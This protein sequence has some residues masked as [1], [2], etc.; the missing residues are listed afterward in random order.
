MTI[1]SDFFKIIKEGCPDAFS[2]NL[3]FKPDIVFIDGQVKLM[4]ATEIN[5]WNLFFA[6][7][8][9]KTIEK[10][11]ALGANTVVLAFD[12]Y[13]HVPS[14]KNM[15]QVKRTK[16]K[17]VLDFANNSKLPVNMPE[18]WAGAMANRTFKVKVINKVLEA[19][20]EW[21]QTKLK[22]DV[23]YRERK[24]VLDYAGVPQLIQ[25]PTDTVYPIQHFINEYDWMPKKNTVGR[26]E[27]D[28]KA[29]VWMHVCKFLCVVSTDGDYLPLALLQTREHSALGTDLQ[30]NHMH[31]NTNNKRVVLYRMTT[32]LPLATPV[33][34]KQLDVEGRSAKTT[35]KTSYKYEFVDIATIDS[36]VQT[37][38]PS[39]A[40]D[41]VRQFC[42]MIAL[43][44]C[45]FVR[46][47]P[48]L[49][50]RTLWKLR[51]MLLH[52]DLREV[53]Q[54]MSALSIAYS[55]LYIM[56]NK[57]PPGIINSVEWFK[58][59]S[60]EQMFAMFDQVSAKIQRTSSISPRIKQQLWQAD[61][62]MAHARNTVWTMH[63]W[64][65]CD[66]CPDPHAT[67]VGDFGYVR[68]SKGR[69]HFACEK[70][71]DP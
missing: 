17:V 43:C 60:E 67:E 50:P 63:Y 57:M 42:A 2:E 32:Q 18:D 7:Q 64:T 69:T 9:Y 58:N 34:R 54:I 11:F 21:F 44:G 36:W 26:G 29:F 27:C 25:L 16:Q 20:S 30:A 47:L 38:F 15:T 39:K 35:T 33:K 68:D 59:A 14:S 52:I 56:K 13:T 40:T 10:C 41:P 53:S 1:N 37:V 23:A 45:D 65:L 4:K 28:I 51:H 55:N 19:T 48:R 66:N 24:L 6:I 31:D 5:S 3:P 8:F 71:P 46:N 22:T 12:D 62:A 61:T 49:G 70:K